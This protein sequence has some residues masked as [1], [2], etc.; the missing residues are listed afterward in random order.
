[1]Q[2]PRVV[3]ATVAILAAAAGDPALGERG[4][5]C[6]APSGAALAIDQPGQ[7]LTAIEYA[8]DVDPA[9]FVLPA[10]VSTTTAATPTSR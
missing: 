1:M 5:F 8:G 7:R 3:L 9:A 4:T 2:A 10:P 6:V